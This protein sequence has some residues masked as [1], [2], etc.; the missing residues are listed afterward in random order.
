MTDR[1]TLNLTVF[2]QIGNFDR[3]PSVEP[4]AN[5]TIFDG[6]RL[7]IAVKASDPDAADV[8]TFS[9]DCPVF[10]IDP[11]TGNADFTPA[12]A[13]AGSYRVTITVRD[14][15]GLAATT[16]FLLT[17]QK[18]NHAPEVSSITP[19]DGTEVLLGGS[20]QFS[21]VA[22]DP[23]GDELNYTWRD[24][25]TVV[26]YGP[27]VTVPFEELAT[28]LITL[29][30]TDGRLSVENETSVIVMTQQTSTGPVNQKRSPLPG[31]AFLVTVGALGVALVALGARKRA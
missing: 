3:P 15:A 6:T 2:N 31:F 4:L 19:E 18:T 17:I 20:L 23:D 22:Q 30:V 21:A 25:A 12:R 29:T 7:Q 9:D 5:Q 26:G 10:D 11:A 13:D 16:L 28:Y 14:Q 24:G 8:L 27:S 1:K